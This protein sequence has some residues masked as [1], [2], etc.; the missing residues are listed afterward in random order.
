MHGLAEGRGDAGGLAVVLFEARGCH[1][2]GRSRR[3][4]RGLG[5]VT[6]WNGSSCADEELGMGWTDGRDAVDG[7]GGGMG[8]SSKQAE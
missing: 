1:G 2:Q 8:L 4:G 3:A 6:E 5:P 7:R